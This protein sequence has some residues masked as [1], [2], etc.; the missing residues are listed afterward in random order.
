MRECFKFDFKE[1]VVNSMSKKVVNI[2]FKPTVRF[3]FDIKLVC[4]AKERL[5]K[6]I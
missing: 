2:T 5:P 3:T 4:N 1:G 6:E